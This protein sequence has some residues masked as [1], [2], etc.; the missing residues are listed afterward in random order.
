MKNLLTF[1][2]LVPLFVFAQKTHTVVAKETMYSIGRLYSIHPRELA[3]FNNIPF[4]KGLEIGQVLKIPAKGKLPAPTATAARPAPSSEVRE[5]GLGM[6]PIYHTVMHGETLYH[7]SISNGKVPIANIKKWNNLTT[8]GV[9]EGTNLIVG[10]RKSMGSAV[11]AESRPKPV[12]PDVVPKVQPQAPQP[13]EVKPA[14]AKTVVVKDAGS[15]STPSVAAGQFNG[16]VF[17]SQYNETSTKATQSGR[18]GVFKSSSGREDGKYY[19]LHNQAPAN[20]IVKIINPQN[21]KA[22]YAKVLD[23]M[24]DLKQNEGLVLRLSNAAADELGVTTSE[25]ECTI[26]Y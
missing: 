16:G 26:N 5:S 12:T 2:F 21:N 9:N 4:D 25:F 19:C 8:D 10:Y 11:V 24:P 13:V 14:P 22:I 3:S 15:E 1:F 7:I 23:V 17:K 18:A 20:S 6:E